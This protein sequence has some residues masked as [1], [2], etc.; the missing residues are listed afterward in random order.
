MTNNNA[1][2]SNTLQ[3]LI[4][5]GI[6]IWL[7][8]FGGISTLS[9][10]LKPGTIGPIAKGISDGARRLS[11]PVA[12]RNAP[13]VPITAPAGSTITKPKPSIASTRTTTVRAGT[14]TKALSAPIATAQPTVLPTVQPTS[15][16]AGGAVELAAP[17]AALGLSVPAG[18]HTM[19]NP[20]GSFTID[21][22]LMRYYPDSTGVIVEARIVD[23]TYE[24]NVSDEGV[25]PEQKIFLDPNNPE[26][27]AY[28]ATLPTAA[29]SMVKGSPCRRGCPKP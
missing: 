5:V 19:I 3:N 10:A 6:V 21:N 1:G 16:S 18:Q 17:P 14:I 27:A 25:P 2:K 4:A 12:K 22:G 20:D 28:I 11:D 9:K 7:L 13:I 8:F 29:P 15:A 23:K 24:P 26:D